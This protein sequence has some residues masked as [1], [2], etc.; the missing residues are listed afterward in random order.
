MRNKSVS[1]SMVNAAGLEHLTTT[2][3]AISIM[4]TL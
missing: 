3:T 2:K 4:I 1:R